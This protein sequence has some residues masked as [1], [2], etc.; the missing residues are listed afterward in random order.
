MGQDRKLLVENRERLVWCLWNNSTRH[1]INKSLW[2]AA[3]LGCASNIKKIEFFWT[4][5]ESFGRGDRIWTCD[6]LRP[7]QVRYQAALRPD[8]MKQGD[9]HSNRF[10][11]YRDLPRFD[12]DFSLFASTVRFPE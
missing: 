10:S 4:D 7:R 11:S 3:A 12:L 9:S 2:T 1:A 6:P 5:K 8:R